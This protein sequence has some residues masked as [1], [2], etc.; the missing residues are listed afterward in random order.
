MVQKEAMEHAI[1]VMDLI[2]DN[3]G[4]SGMVDLYIDGIEGLGDEQYDEV[5]SIVWD[6]LTRYTEEQR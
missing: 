1:D 2:T 3:D 6:L 4:L 5:Y